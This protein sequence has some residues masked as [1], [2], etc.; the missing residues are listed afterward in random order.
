VIDVDVLMLD[1]RVFE[2]DRLVL[3]HPSI[4]ERRF[5]LVPL[6]ELD[7]PGGARFAEALETLGAGQEV[8]KVGPPLI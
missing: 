7:P 4:L 6:L 2:S 5:V 1:E 8:H 3:P